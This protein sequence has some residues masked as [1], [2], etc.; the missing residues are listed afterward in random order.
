MNGVKITEYE[1][2]ALN[3]LAREQLKHKILADILI[4]MQICKIEG[5][6]MKEYI[7]ELK[8]MLDE[9]IAKNNLCGK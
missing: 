5:R 9:I 4:D 7:L 8:N 2:K 3:T 1:A 6:D